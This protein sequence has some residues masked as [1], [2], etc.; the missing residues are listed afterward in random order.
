M[1]DRNTEKP[2]VSVI[3]PCRNEEAFIG[4]V[5]QHL[6]GQDFQGTFEILIVDAGST[7]RTV[8]IVEETKKNSD[9]K[10]RILTN[11]KVI[12]PAGVNIGI[13]N[14]FG[15]IIIRMDGHAA[16]DKKYIR[17]AVEALAEG[18]D[19]VG[20]ICTSRPAGDSLVAKA[21]SAG[22]SH[23]FGVGDSRFRTTHSKGKPRLVDTVP[24]GCFRKQLWERLGGYNETLLTNEDYDFNYRVRKI[25]GTV[26]LNPQIMADYYGR[27]T[28][29]TLAGQYYRY[30]KWKMIMLTSQPRSL[31]WRHA[32]PPL[33]IL[34]TLTFT[35]LSFSSILFRKLALY[36]LLGYFIMNIAASLHAA[37]KNRAPST[38]FI[39]P[40]VFFIMHISW[41][42]G[43]LL[44]FC[45]LVFARRRSLT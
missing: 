5:L 20:G 41:G 13:K 36:E 35:L 16:P 10:I 32:V 12:I 18:Y 2:S 39:L 23:I 38:V 43:M 1:K 33:F 4:R 30:G 40:L 27:K 25:G 42:G 9:L 44:S 17:L 45:Q 15:E 28:L 31:R 11:T 22:I 24:F 14:A 37:V 29:A 34:S 8:K 21:V 26:F 6:E 19:V 7:D 3:I